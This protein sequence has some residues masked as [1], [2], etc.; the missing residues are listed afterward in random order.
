MQ[1]IDIPDKNTVVG[2]IL[3]LSGNVLLASSTQYN[4]DGTI[5]RQVMVYEKNLEEGQWVHKEI[6]NIPASSSNTDP[7]FEWNKPD[8]FWQFNEIMY[9]Y[10][11]P[12]KYYYHDNNDESNYLVANQLA[13]TIF[14]PGTNYS[15]KAI[16]NN[17]CIY[18]SYSREDF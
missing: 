14:G 7:R 18:K 1:K 15:Y 2:E 8:Q 13:T 6:I 5:S 17:L 9:S 11:L 16:D 12:D 10:Q 3:S 4:S